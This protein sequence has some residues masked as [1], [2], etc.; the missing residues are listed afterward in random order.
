MLRQLGRLAPFRQSTDDGYRQQH[1]KCEAEGRAQPGVQPG[2][3]TVTHHGGQAG[4]AC[5]AADSD[6]TGLSA[7]VR[8]GWFMV[9]VFA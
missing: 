9:I 5:T 8:T 7:A 6:R 3:R 4:C 1:A 2:E